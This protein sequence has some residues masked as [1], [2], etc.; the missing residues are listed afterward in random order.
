[1]GIQLQAGS[2]S[3]EDSQGRENGSLG[4]VTEAPGAVLRRRTRG[5]LFGDNAWKEPLS[6]GK[7]RFCGIR[8]SYNE[9]SSL[10]EKNRKL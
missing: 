7:A 8:N 4:L 5:F 1:M 10:Y 2:A 9:G 3:R 6:R